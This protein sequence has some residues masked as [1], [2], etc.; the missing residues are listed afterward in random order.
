MGKVAVDPLCYTTRW[1]VRSYEIDQNGHVNNAVYLQYAE[2]VTVEHAELSGFG[3]RWSEAHGG[4]WVV[5][6]NEV[7]YFRPAVLG[8]E[9][10]LT[11]RVES[12]QGVRGVRR[13]TIR[14]VEDG[15]PVAEVLTEW[16]WVRAADGRPQRVPQ[17]L[18]DVAAEVTAALRRRRSPS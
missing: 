14:R 2:A 12:V 10:E 18:V 16:V 9:L 8:D 13:T 7:R 6:R 17:E 11:V 3:R 15:G 5:H 4:G 1:R